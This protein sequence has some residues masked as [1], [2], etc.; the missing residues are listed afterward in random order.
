MLQLEKVLSSQAM[1][2]RVKRWHTW[3]TIRANTVGEHSARVALIYMEMWGLPRAEVLQWCL[4]H[5][6]GELSAGDVP[7]YAKRDVPELKGA[8]DQA[9]AMGRLT[10]GV[11]LPE[12]TKKEYDRVRIA[13]ALEGW[14]SA[15]I[16]YAMG[17]AFAAIAQDFMGKKAWQK[18]ID[19][20]EEMTV[21][22]F[23][24]KEF[25]E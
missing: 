11:V 19:A 23:M 1:A 9:E 21:L 16:D 18:A 15:A 14:E 8:I 2:V 12:L 7:S 6:L 20:K 3:P 25:G 10:Q 5:D 4:Y 17:N 13:D 22:N 24:K